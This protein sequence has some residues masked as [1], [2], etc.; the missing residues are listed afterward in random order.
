MNPDEA[1][2]LLREELEETLADPGDGPATPIGLTIVPPAD[3]A[4]DTA[5]RIRA[6]RGPHMVETDLPT[7]LAI[8]YLADEEA[9]VDEWKSWVAG[10]RSSLGIIGPGLRD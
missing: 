1:A 3:L 10:L 7:G 8:A 4:P 2:R 9:A 6:S 5:F